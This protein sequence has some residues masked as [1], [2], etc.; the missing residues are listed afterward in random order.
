VLRDGVI[1]QVGTPDEIYDAPV[2]RFVAGFM[3]SPKMSF[4]QATVRETAGTR[5][6]LDIA[7]ISGGPVELDVAG[8]AALSGQLT[9]GLRPEHFLPRDPVGP[10][11]VADIEFVERLGGESFL[12]APSHPAGALVIKQ[13]ETGGAAKAGGAREIGVDWRKAHLFAADGSA[14]ALRRE[15]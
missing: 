8:S 4:L 14:I 5:L 11:L 12:H 15:T 9:V 6:A 1:E 7:G 10:K 2:N 3:G 13:S